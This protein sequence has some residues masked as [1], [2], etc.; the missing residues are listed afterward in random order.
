MRPCQIV[1]HGRP[2]E[3]A[4]VP[5]PAVPDGSVLVEVTVAPMTPLDVL[6]ASGSSYFGAPALPY[7]PGVQGVGWVA[8]T[9]QRVWFTTDAGMRPGDGSLAER[10]AV[11]TDRM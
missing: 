6:I 2:P 5:A 7:I 11:P 1:A 8:G 4:A 10:A 9:G 3:R